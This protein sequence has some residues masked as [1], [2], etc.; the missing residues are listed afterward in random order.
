MKRKLTT[1]NSGFSLVEVIVSMLIIAI[2]V[3]GLAPMFVLSVEGNVVA[4]DSSV[5]SNLINESLEHYSDVSNIPFVPYTDTEILP[6][7]ATQHPEPGSPGQYPKESNPAFN[8]LRST[9]IADNSVD[10]LIP[11]GV[12]E[13]IVA[14]TWTDHQNVQRSS[15]YTTYVLKDE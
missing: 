14:I 5:V 15:S 1:D 3:L 7:S 9:Y 2:G 11:A 4:R 13:V 6:M 8:F 10:S 12:Y